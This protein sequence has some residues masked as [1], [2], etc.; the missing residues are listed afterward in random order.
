MLCCRGNASDVLTSRK[1]YSE[2]NDGYPGMLPAEVDKVFDSVSE[3]KALI[4]VS[5]LQ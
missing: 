2:A 4:D 1:G 5:E 3:G